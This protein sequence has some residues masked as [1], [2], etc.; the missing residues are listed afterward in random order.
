MPTTG[1][2]LTHLGFGMPTFLA[3]GT[4]VFNSMI[5]DVTKESEYEDLLE[6]TTKIA[7][8]GSWEMGLNNQEDDS[9]LWSPII[10]DVLELNDDTPATLEGL[11]D[12]YVLE[13]K[14][15][16]GRAIDNLIKEGLNFDEEL[17]LIT[18]K[19]NEQWVRVIGSREVINKRPTKIYG[20]IQDINEK[21]IARLELEKSL[22]SL[23]D[24]KFSLD[25][26]AII[27]FTDQKG[28]ITSVN[29]NFCKISGYKREELIGKTHRIIN[30]NHHP[31]TFFKDLWKTI[32]SGKVFRGEIKNQ[33]KDGSYYWVDTTIVPFL[34]EK[35]RPTQ[36]LAIRF[37]ITDRKEAEEKLAFA[38]ERLR[39]A[40]SSAKMG[41]WDWDITNDNLTWDDR[42]YELYGV[43]EGDFDGALAAWEKGLH[44][45]DIGKARADL[46]DALKGERDFNSVFRVVWPDKSVH[47]IE[48]NAI[49][50]RDK[51]GKALRMIGGNIDITERRKAEQDILKANERFE[52][53]TEATNDV[54]WDWDIV[55]DKLYR[56]KAIERFFGTKASKS[57]TQADFWKDYFHPDDKDKVRQSVEEAVANPQ[58]SRWKAEYRVLNELGEV[59]YVIDQGVIIRNKEGKATRMVGAMTDVTEQRKSE[60]EDRFKAN[61]L[62]T[63]EQAAIATNMEGEVN[64]WNK[65]AETIY[66]WTKEEALGKNIDLLRPR[67]IDEEEDKKIKEILMS[68][69]AWSGEHTVQRKDGTKFPVRV[70]NAPVYDENN[71]II[72]IIGISSD[73]TQEVENEKLLKQYTED[74]ERSNQKLRKIAWTQSHVVRAPLSRILGIINLIELQEGKMDDILTWIEQLK[75]ST[76]EMD[77]I[78]KKIVDEANHLD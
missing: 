16:L 49:V 53:V 13:S 42:M 47:F 69:K 41:I 70:S 62:K 51:K 59:L 7:R 71:K 23:N 54:I 9:M 48:G 78:V 68:G 56:P 11:L 34:N 1:K 74:L 43:K 6:Q 39:L 18:A 26:A 14:Q 22:K 45:N 65:A 8:I 36:Y 31:A 33:A 55:H 29:E 64:Y 72:G 30:S 24:Y 77:V 44:P 17:L 12:H 67:D 35:D 37:D 76:M 21:K 25:Q 3:D 4:I 73:T 61:L 46:S 60:K 63:V 28:V 40:T 66:G 50:S 38:A 19:G 10:R 27:A 75:I 32:G 57:L 58:A 52:K 20:S 2:L 15:R 5:L